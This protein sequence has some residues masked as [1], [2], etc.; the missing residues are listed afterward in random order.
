MK[1]VSHIKTPMYVQQCNVC[2]HTQTTKNV[3]QTT[4]LGF[5]LYKHAASDSKLVQNIKMQ[6]YI[7]QPASPYSILKLGHFKVACLGLSNTVI[8]SSNTCVHICAYFS[9]SIYL[10]SSQPCIHDANI[11]AIYIKCYLVLNLTS[12]CLQKEDMR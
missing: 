4:T 8:S 5:L 12:N 2:K 3:Q 6:T 11:F 7:L 1:C 10:P 9:S